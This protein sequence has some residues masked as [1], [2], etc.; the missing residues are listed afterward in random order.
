[1]GAT[2]VPVRMTPMPSPGPTASSGSTSGAPPSKTPAE[3][4][5]PGQVLIRLSTRDPMLD[6]YDG[7]PLL[8]VLENQESSPR[9]DGQYPLRVLMLGSHQEGPGAS[10]I[11]RIVQGS[12]QRGT[13]CLLRPGWRRLLVQRVRD[14]QSN[15]EGMIANP[16]DYVDLLVA[17]MPDYATVNRSA[18]ASAGPQPLPVSGLKSAALWGSTAGESQQWLVELRILELEESDQPKV[19]RG[20]YG[21]L[22]FGA[23]A[24]GAEIV[25]L[26]EALDLMTEVRSSLPTEALPGTL[27]QCIVKLRRPTALDTFSGGQLGRFV[28]RRAGHTVG[29]GKVVAAAV[30]SS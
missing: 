4:L 27:T 28:L 23:E 20:F 8:K 7:D 26:I 15:T 25:E 11:G 29:V 5:P 12:A 10:L 13:E 14:P 6:W 17:P 1:M 30:A 16:G 24:V 2:F 21:M 19:G 22:Y 18:D 9:T 3:A